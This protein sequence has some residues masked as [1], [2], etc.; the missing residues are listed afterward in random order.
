[1]YKEHATAKSVL[2]E[3]HISISEFGLTFPIPNPNSAKTW[4]TNLAVHCILT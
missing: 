4:K 2:E 3:F 1:M